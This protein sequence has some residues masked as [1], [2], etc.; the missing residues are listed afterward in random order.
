[1]PATKIKS[2]RDSIR[3]E[4]ARPQKRFK[5]SHDDSV[6][7]PDGTNYYTKPGDFIFYSPNVDIVW[8]HT[9]H[10][11]YDYVNLNTILGEMR[12]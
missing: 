9:K 7:L 4:T 5:V 10:I 12:K 6:L 8:L 2:V 11:V 1:M 3:L